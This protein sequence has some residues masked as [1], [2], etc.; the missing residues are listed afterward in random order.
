VRTHDTVRDG[1]DHGWALER[2]IELEHF[3][4]TQPTLEDI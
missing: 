2:G 4:V 1:G 3:S